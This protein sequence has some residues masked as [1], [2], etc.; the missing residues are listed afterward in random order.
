MIFSKI[1]KHFSL[2]LIRLTEKPTIQKMLSENDQCLN[3]IISSFVQLKLGEF[4][5]ED[6]RVFNRC[7]EYRKSLLNNHTL[8]SYEIFR[9]NKSMKVNEI[10]RQAA[11]QRIW[12]K[13]LYL[14]T[15]KNTSPYFLEIGTNLGV[16]GSYILEALKDKTDSNFITMEG[17]PQLCQ[18]ANN[19]FLKIS[20]SE[21]F[22]IIQGLYETTFAHLLRKNIN[23]NILFID[24]N[25]R[26]DATVEYF[27]TLK[28]I[29]EFPAIFIFDDINWSDEMQQAWKIVKADL[30]VS[31]SIDMFKLGIIVIN[32]KTNKSKAKHYYLHLAY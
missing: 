20:S 25:H 22:T 28:S 2:F 30:D 12:A 27:N 29:I 9:Q 17:L 5:S 6:A 8:I 7:E 1:K 26:K 11:S 21:K 32:K 23:F 15:K 3:D 31:Y 13:F 19:Q 16:S 14:I 24:G 18:I 4:E 10:Y